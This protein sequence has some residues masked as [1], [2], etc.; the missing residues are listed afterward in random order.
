MSAEVGAPSAVPA[1][2]H[3]S[4]DAPPPDAGAPALG[5]ERGLWRDA[6]R[7]TFRKTSARIGGVLLSIILALAALAP[8]IAPHSPTE[9][10]L[11]G[12]KVAKSIKPC[13]H[14]LGCAA[15]KPQFIMG[16]DKNGRDVFSRIVFG[17]RISLLAGAAAVVFAL[18]VGV[19]LGLVAGYRAGWL[20]N[21]I[22][23]I[24]DVLLAFP[25]LLLAITIVTVLGPGLL[26]AIIAISVVTIPVYARV[27]R[28]S[29][30]SIK[31]QE[32]VT[33]DR[34]LG[35]RGPRL[36]LHRILPNALTPLVVQATLGF[37]TAVLDVAGLSF[38]GLGVRPPKA[39]WGSMIAGSR[40]VVFTSPH[41][42]F[43]PGV[44][45]LINVL[46]FNLIGD[47]LRDALDPRLNR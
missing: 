5:R 35:V 23:R 18:V 39:E 47:G 32:F 15:S 19:A 20:G 6:L 13:I 33:A 12:G 2:A 14:L 42:V 22:M 28:A 11:I 45:I 4:G 1:A 26:N 3:D 25:S 46:A 17:S 10:L 38:L 24:M 44:M 27:V 36:V 21:V 34:A 7:E 29:V 16:T 31:E 40:D 30:L 37:A 9:P 43:F 8:V 41:Q